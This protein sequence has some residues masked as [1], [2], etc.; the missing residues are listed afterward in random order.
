MEVRCTCTLLDCVAFGYGVE[1]GAGSSGSATDRRLL[2]AGQSSGGLSYSLYRDATH[3]LVWDVG[4]NKLSVTYLL[5]LFGSWQRSYVYGRI[6][7]GQVV[8]TGAYSDA[9][10]V[11]LTY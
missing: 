4:A 9:P 10:T 6:P 7:A 3:L 1:I 5:A 2:K 11:I 8:S